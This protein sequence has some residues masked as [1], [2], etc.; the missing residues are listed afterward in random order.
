MRV[1]WASAYAVA[2]SLALALILLGRLPVGRCQDFSGGINP[3]PTSPLLW[4]LNDA[5]DNLTRN[6]FPAVKDR[7]G[8]CIKDPQQDW[9]QTFNYTNNLD[10]L[11][12]CATKLPG[13]GLHFFLTKLVPSPPITTLAN[14]QYF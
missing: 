12:D 13:M 2:V 9:D 3:P 8:F 4:L 6:I 7:F 5:V 14:C 10:F 1:S 11:R